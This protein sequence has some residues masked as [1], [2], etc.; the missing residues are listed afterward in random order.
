MDLNTVLLAFD[1]LRPSR[2]NQKP[3][4]A[5]AQ[6]SGEDVRA[7]ASICMYHTDHLSHVFHLV[8]FISWLFVRVCS[9]L[10]H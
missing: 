7:S 1:I 4:R 10:K 3:S 2:V 9:A 8:Y 6:R 5:V